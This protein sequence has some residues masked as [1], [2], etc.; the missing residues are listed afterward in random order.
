MSILSG[1]C[2][3]CGERI[4]LCQT[5]IGNWQWLTKVNQRKTWRC[6]SDSEFPLRSHEPISIAE[7][8]NKS[9]SLT[10]CFAVGGL[11]ALLS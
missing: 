10:K 6:G 9:W 3:D 4:W 2:G 7:P 5:G 1:V 8:V 11:L